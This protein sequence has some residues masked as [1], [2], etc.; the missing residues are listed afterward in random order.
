MVS[1][2]YKDF[3]PLGKVIDIEVNPCREYDT[4]T[5]QEDWTPDKCI[6]QCEPNEAQFWSVYIVYDGKSAQGIDCIA[7]FLEETNADNLAALL[8]TLMKLESV[9]A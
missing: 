3:K 6:E 5:G 1:C 2:I 4:N 8:K 7:D 9:P